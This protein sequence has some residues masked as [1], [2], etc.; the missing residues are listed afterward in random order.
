M[1]S[2]TEC[3]AE[4]EEEVVVPGGGSRTTYYVVGIA[5]VALLVFVGIS[6]YNKK[7]ISEIENYDGERD[8]NISLI[9]KA[10]KRV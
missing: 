9:Y 6:K 4:K 7:R 1:N 3:K 10:E 8:A 2:G 5:I